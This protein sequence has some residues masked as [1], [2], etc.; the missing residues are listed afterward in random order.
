MVGVCHGYQAAVRQLQLVE[1][2]IWAILHGAEAA[3]PGEILPDIHGDDEVGRKE[4]YLLQ[5]EVAGRIS[6][7]GSG[8]LRC[9]LGAGKLDEAADETAVR[10]PAAALVAELGQVHKGKAESALHSQLL[11]QGA[12]RGNLLPGRQ[13]VLHGPGK[14]QHQRVE[15]VPVQAGARHPLLLVGGKQHV[16]VILT[17]HLQRLPPDEQQGDFLHGVAGIQSIRHQQVPGKPRQP[18][19]VHRLSPPGKE[20]MQLVYEV[21]LAG[22]IQILVHG[23]ASLQRGG[24]L[25]VGTVEAVPRHQLLQVGILCPAILAVVQGLF[26]ALIQLVAAVSPVWIVQAVARYQQVQVGLLYAAIFAIVEFHCASVDKFF[27]GNAANFHWKFRENSLDFEGIS[28][29]NWG[30]IQWKIS[31]WVVDWNRLRWEST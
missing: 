14:P 30:K 1:A 10:L 28:T 23:H 18:R 8:G 25:A 21:V 16:D 9:W 31:C 7:A 24:M 11:R 29:G 4:S 13:P 2:H 27:S 17:L 5:D 26:R 12:C 20:G 6:G 15:L 19:S 3:N 22:G